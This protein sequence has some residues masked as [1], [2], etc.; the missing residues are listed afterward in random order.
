M[1]PVVH[2]LSRDAERL[3]DVGGRGPQLA[4]LQDARGLQLVELAPETTDR[5]ERLEG[6]IRGLELPDEPTREL[7]DPHLGTV[8]GF[9][10]TAV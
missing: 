2:G 9:G 8:P 3:A 10:D 6:E 4:G 5:L 7:Q 1:Q